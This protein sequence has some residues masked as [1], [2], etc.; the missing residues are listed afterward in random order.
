V[1]VPHL[2]SREQWERAQA[3]FGEKLPVGRP[4]S[5]CLVRGLLFCPCGRRMIGEL[6]RKSR[7]YRCSGR[8]ATRHN[9]ERCTR[10]LPVEKTDS[11][12]WETLSAAL[13]DAGALRN[14][15]QATQR[16]ADASLPER[17]D[18][19]SRQLQ[20]LRSREDRCLSLM[21]DGELAN[22]PALKAKYLTVQR[23]RAAV[24]R[25]LA[26]AQA[27][28]RKQAASAG[29]LERAAANLRGYLP[30]IESREKRQAFVQAMVS[31]VEWDGVD[32]MKMHCIL[33]AEMAQ[34]CSRSDLFSP[35]DSLSVVP[36][37]DSLQIILTARFAA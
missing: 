19:L 16:D 34:T 6:S 21:V 37:F 35:S 2:V 31:R 28:S 22:V 20:T 23:E 4:S 11:L 7:S 14:I 1:P 15:L 30:T 3:R 17:V 33:G 12:L 9:G 5:S 13:T 18:A 8:D 24:E 25:E 36:A 26:G 32:V 10:S 29:W 27:A